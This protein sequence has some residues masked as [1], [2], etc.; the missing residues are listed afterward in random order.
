MEK[1][2]VYLCMMHIRQV[3]CTVETFQDKE[4]NVGLDVSSEANFGLDVSSEFH[5]DVSSENEE[6]EAGLDASSEFLFQ[7]RVPLWY[8]F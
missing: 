1:W 3:W 4:A 6:A 2:L 5:F 7:L 8:E